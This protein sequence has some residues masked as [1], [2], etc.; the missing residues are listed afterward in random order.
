M[1]GKTLNHFKVLD[2]LGKGGM[3]EVYVAEDGKLKRKV[4]LK[5]LPEDVARD[6]ARLDRFQREAESIAALNHPNIVTIYSIEEADGIR[7]LTM[8]LV[9]GETL[10]QLIPSNGMD[11]E[12][13]LRFSA[14]VAEALSAAHEKGIIHRDLKPGNIM[15]SHEGRIKVLDFGLAKLMRDDSDPDS[16]RMET[17]AQTEAGIVLGTMPYMSPEQIQGKKLDQRSDIFSLGII[18]YEMITGRRPFHGDTSAELISAIMRDTPGPV[19]DLKAGMPEHLERIIRR[20]LM[21][22]P[23]DRY[24]TARDVYNELRDLNASSGSTTRRASGSAS[25]GNSIAVLPFTN[26]SVVKM[27]IF[28][29]AWR[30]NCSMRW[31]RLKI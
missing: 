13:F 17:H 7:F 4:A 30:K 3:G 21:K 8:E 27:N 10:I 19:G 1:I 16:S 31:R 28:V 2:R 9:E 15:I 22:D 25:G 29:T 14:P 24:Q 26:M 18:F 23:R 12:S 11:V 20:C 6:P 5:V